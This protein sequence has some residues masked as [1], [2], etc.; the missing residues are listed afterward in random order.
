MSAT[1]ALH[2]VEFAGQGFQHH[3]RAAATPPMLPPTTAPTSSG[4]AAGGSNAATTWAAMANYK[5]S[6]AEPNAD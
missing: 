2:P 3:Q 6:A 4:P 1:D 5:A